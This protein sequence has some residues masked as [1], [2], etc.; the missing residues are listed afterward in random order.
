MPP[1]EPREPFALDFLHIPQPNAAPGERW[2]IMTD[3]AMPLA[4][5]SK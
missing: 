5:R 1:P 4:P 2:T 3:L